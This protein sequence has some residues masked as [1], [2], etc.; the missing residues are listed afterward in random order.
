M[1]R[2]VSLC[3]L[4]FATLPAVAQASS[5]VPLAEHRTWLKL[6]HFDQ[7]PFF[8]QPHSAVVDDRFFLSPEGKHNPSAELTATIVALEQTDPG[9]GSHAS[10]RFPARAMWLA[11]QGVVQPVSAQCEKRDAWLRERQDHHVGVVFASG[12]MGNPASF[13]GHM[14]LHLGQPSP[15]Q[16]S[17]QLL[18]TSL[19]FGADTQ[20]D[21][22]VPYILKGLFGGYQARYSNVPFFRNADI[23]SESEMRD[24]WHYQLN[25]TPA[26]SAFFIA[27]LW[28]IMGQDFDYLFLSENCASRIARSLEL[29]VDA[30]LAASPMPWVAPEHVMIQLSN[31]QYQGQPLVQSRMHKPSRR[32]QTEHYFHQ[33]SEVQQLALNAVW[34]SPE[35]LHFELPDFAELAPLQRA[36]ILDVILSHLITLEEAESTLPINTL[37]QQ[38]LMARLRLPTSNPFEQPPAPQPIEQATPSLMA[39]AG[40]VAAS[41]RPTA[42][43]LSV[44]PMHYD[45]LQSNNT[46]MPYAGLELFK[47]EADITQDGMRIHALD[48][49]NVTNF[50]PR[51]TSLPEMGQMAWQMKLTVRNRHL[52]CDDCLDTRAELNIG[53]SDY[54]N[55][56]VPFA[57]V[58]AQ[59]RTTVHQ[60]GVAALTLNT[61]FFRSWNDK[62]SSYLTLH[63]ENGFQGSFSHNTELRLQHRLQLRR[64]QDVRFHLASDRYGTEAGVSMSWYW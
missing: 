23:Y 60:E 36:A 32:Y 28:E 42:L 37:R 22:I 34:A 44:R 49:L 26:D 29:V 54:M 56:W 18:D 8:E 1:C 41:Q 63:H 3:F 33:L 59:L 17:I 50:N 7:T 16:S 2:F 14:M 10:C 40:L 27:H 15:A 58:G 43:R 9:D 19:N 52:A 24:M 39:R 47:L 12:Y 46:R 13:F 35:T 61:G 45:I 31:A 57:L 62:Q 38:A 5:S 6:L 21:G 4:F 20:G 48:L 51:R 53:W 55:G 25:L 64:E 11:Q 30:D